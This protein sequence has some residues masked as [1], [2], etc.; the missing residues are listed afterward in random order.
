M[1]IIDPIEHIRSHPDM[2]LWGG[3]AS[4]SDLASRLTADALLLGASRTLV[5]HTDQWWAVAADVDWLAGAVVSADALFGRIVP[6][7]QAGVNSMRSEV[8]LTAFADDVVTWS[9]G[10]RPRRVKG[11]EADWTVVHA[12]IADASWRRVIA[13]RLQPTGAGAPSSRAVASSK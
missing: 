13:F 11:A 8:L 7:P 5:V 10:D 2:Y 4:P 6:F 9:E 3:S 12:K 1:K